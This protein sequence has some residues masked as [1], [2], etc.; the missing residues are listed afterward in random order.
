MDGITTTST[1]SGV[2][3]DG[4]VNAWHIAGVV[5]RMGRREWL[6][7]AGWQQM[8]DAGIRTV[9]DLRTL[10]EQQ[11]REVDPEVSA[12]AMARFDI[13]HCPTEDPENK[14]FTELFGP[15]LKD[16]AHYAD[17]LRLF[18]E[19]LAAVFKAIAAAR[20]GVVVHCAAGRDR[21]G[22]IA[23]M[24]QNLAGAGDEE[25]VRGYQQGMRGINERHRHHRAPHAHDAFL[26]EDALEAMLASRRV[27]LLEFAHSLDVIAFLRANGVS[28]AEIAAVRA[29]LG[30]RAD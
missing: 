23:V 26:E 17:Y 19:N 25:I 12:E 4:A 29:K 15:Y 18:S 27:S 3:W 20:G 1:Q 30:C 2:R 7:D 6:T 5:Y 22:I 8:Y 28:E 21:A 13:V 16:P 10:R 14:A 11:P 9:I 24:L